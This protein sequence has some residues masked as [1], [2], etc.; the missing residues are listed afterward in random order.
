MERMMENQ[1]HG[2]FAIANEELSEFLRRV[3]GLATGTETITEKDLQ[4]LS[5]RL[6]TLA[7]EVG[8]ASRGETLD[9]AL[10]N[11]IAKYV[12][13][14]RA[15]QFALEKVRCIMLARKVQLDGAKRHLHSLQGWVHAY[16]Q[17]T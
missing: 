16:N 10:Q 8:D 6:S 15:L 1:K 7:P 9:G 2:R 12:K 5:Q 17:T 14:L 3:D 13:N 4:S 11:E